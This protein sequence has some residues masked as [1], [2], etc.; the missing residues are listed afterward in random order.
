MCINEYNIAVVGLGYVGLPLAVEFGKHFITKG[1]DIS[2]KRVSELRDH[3]DLTNEC[4][5]QSIASAKHLSFVSDLNSIIDCNIY[6]ITVPTPI[7][8]Q[9]I[10]D[11]NPLLSATEAVASILNMGDTVIFESTVYPGLT[12]ELCIPILEKISKLI[13]NKDFYVGYSPERVNPGDKVNTLPNITKIVSGSSQAALHLVDD[14]YKRIIT[15]GTYIASSIKVAE[16]AKVI[17]NSQRDINIAFINEL[18]MLFSKLEIDTMEVLNAASSKWNFLQFKPG[19]VGGHCIG[20]DPYYLA[21]KAQQVNFNPRIILNG[22]AINEEMP[23]YCIK[24]VIKTAKKQGLNL[25][26]AKIAILGVTFKEN[27]PDIRNTKVFELVQEVQDWGFDLQLHDPIANV[28]DVKELFGLNLTDISKIKADIIIVAVSHDMYRKFST[29][30]LVSLIS[31]NKGVIAD[32]KSIFDISEI[33]QYGH[34]VF[35][36]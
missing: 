4:T 30:N 5:A 20:V 15:A 7:D 25:S 35:R 1:Y 18:S 33:K 29:A 10:P 34:G 13:I 17:E 11:L 19:L 24:E 6:I 9:N 3:L 14:L 8:G 22:R 21:F 36:L 12:E 23:K 32:L 26:S 2:Y 31:S 16:A 28:N 27:C